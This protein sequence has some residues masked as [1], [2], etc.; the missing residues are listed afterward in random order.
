MKLYALGVGPGA[1]DLLTLRAAEILKRVPVIFSPLSAMG[2]TSRAL[3]VVRPLLDPSRQQVVELEFPM[4]KEQ[5][6][7]EG[8]WEEVAAQIVEQLR[9]HGE[10]AFITIGDVSLY[11]TF[12]YVQRILALQHP[13]LVIELVPGIPSF[14]AVSALLGIP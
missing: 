1:P 14:P 4:Q 11:S 3:D 6:E 2:T 7:L 13:D 12:G 10:G 9:R 5:D 8:E